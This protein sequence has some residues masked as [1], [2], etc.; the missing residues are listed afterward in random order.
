MANLT[1]EEILRG[2]IDGTIEEIISDDAFSIETYKLYG[3]SRLRRVT[4]PNI[5]SVGAQAFRSNPSLVDVDLLN[6]TNVWTS[7]FQ[8]S[9]SSEMGV[10]RFD[11]NVVIGTNSFN[12]SK[13]GGVIGPNVSSLAYETAFEGCTRMKFAIFPK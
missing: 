11:K 12:G 3:E 8:W 6:A 10:L 7:A 4:I 13:I 1:P 9:G 2:I 5:K